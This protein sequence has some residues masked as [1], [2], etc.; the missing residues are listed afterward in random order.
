MHQL[1]NKNSLTNQN[2]TKQIKY[3]TTLS[4]NRTQI[5]YSCDF[6][7]TKILEKGTHQ[8]RLFTKELIHI[9]IYTPI[10]LTI[11]PTLLNYHLLIPQYVL[12]K[13]FISHFTSPNL[14]N[15]CLFTSTHGSFY[16][17]CVCLSHSFL[18]LSSVYSFCL[19][20]FVLLIYT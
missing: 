8:K 17:F 4:Q 18:N 6:N 11:T 2:N 20:Q 12:C 14:L 1:S 10:Q 16:A 15:Y 13:L 7:N 19:Y 5:T 9:Y 3:T